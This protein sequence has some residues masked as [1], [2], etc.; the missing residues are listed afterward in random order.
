M[1]KKTTANKMDMLYDFFITHYMHNVEWKLF[2]MFEKD[3][4]LI[5]KLNRNWRHHLIRKNSHVTFDNQ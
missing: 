4:T 5:N 3:K 2:S 1:N